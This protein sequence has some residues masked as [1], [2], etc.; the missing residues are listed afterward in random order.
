MNGFLENWMNPGLEKLER[1]SFPPTSGSLYHREGF[2]GTTRA[3]KA[4]CLRGFT[5][6]RVGGL[7]SQ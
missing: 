5:S 1:P 3:I 6:I 7:T 4:F 2:S